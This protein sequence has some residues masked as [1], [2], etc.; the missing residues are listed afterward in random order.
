MTDW[1]DVK[2]FLNVFS[3]FFPVE[4]KNNNNNLL[5]NPRHWSPPQLRHPEHFSVNSV[6]YAIVEKFISS[7]NVTLK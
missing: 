3:F 4:K 7:S 2:M 6:T 1:I 5:M